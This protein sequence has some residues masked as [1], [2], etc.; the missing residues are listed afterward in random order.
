MFVFTEGDLNARPKRSLVCA[1]H[2]RDVN[3]VQVPYRKTRTCFGVS[4]SGSVGKLGS[5]SSGQ[6]AKLKW[7]RR[8]GR[9]PH[10][11]IK[12][13]NCVQDMA[14]GSVVSERIKVS[15]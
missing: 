7:G 15:F 5:E 11:N 4:A 1:Q 13:V 2:G 9:V 10:F 14:P 8:W 6:G 12:S 3:V